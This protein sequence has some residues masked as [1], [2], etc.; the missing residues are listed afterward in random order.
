[1]TKLAEQFQRLVDN[2][3]IKPAINA[4][5]IE[6]LYETLAAASDKVQSHTIDLFDNLQGGVKKSYNLTAELYK[7]SWTAGQDLVA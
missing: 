5:H 7:D 6:P 3:L 4:P 2:G 1:M